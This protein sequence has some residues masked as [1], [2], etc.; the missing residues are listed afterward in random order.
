MGMS[1]LVEPGQNCEIRGSR[2]LARS[3]GVEKLDILIAPNTQDVLNVGNE[4]L[5]REG[6]VLVRLGAGVT[7]GGQDYEGYYT[8]FLPTGTVGLLTGQDDASTAV[9]LAHDVDM[10]RIAADVAA[11]GAT[12]GEKYTTDASS[13]TT[14][15]FALSE[16]K[17]D[18]DFFLAA[19]LVKRQRLQFLPR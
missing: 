12:F 10:S 5:L 18:A 3:E 16:V 6:L 4:D 14:G 7:I 17:A 13:Y 9:I 19:N 15:T 2:I 8:H 11:D 1:T